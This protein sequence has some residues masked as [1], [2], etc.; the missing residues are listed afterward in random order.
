[1]QNGTIRFNVSLTDPDHARLRPGLKVDVHVIHGLKDDVLRLNSGSY[2]IG[3]GEYDL[4]VI[5][6]GIA[7]RRKITLGESSFEYVEVIQGLQKGEQVIISDMNR[8]QNKNTLKIIE[9]ERI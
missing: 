3:P 6:N 4:W 9:N 7:T 8:Y 2:Y 5:D 1:M